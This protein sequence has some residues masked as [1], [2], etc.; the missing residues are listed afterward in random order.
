MLGKLEQIGLMGKSFFGS[1]ERQVG[2]DVR[3]AA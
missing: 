1:F 2:K 3:H